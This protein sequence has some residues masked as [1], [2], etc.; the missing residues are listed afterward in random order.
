VLVQG[1]RREGKGEVGWPKENGPREQEM[2]LGQAKKNQWPVREKST[3]WANARD[4][5][6]IQTIL[7]F[8]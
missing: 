6:Q 2:K 8:F 3:G 4:S 5:G 1:R 7:F